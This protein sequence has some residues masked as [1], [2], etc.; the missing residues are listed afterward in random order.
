M[1]FEEYQ[2][3]CSWITHMNMHKS[4]NKS[5]EGDKKT[6]TFKIEIQPQIQNNS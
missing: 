4:V 3:I 5:G 1:N 6:E 2:Q